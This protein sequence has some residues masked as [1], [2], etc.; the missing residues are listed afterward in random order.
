MESF[1]VDRPEEVS[2]KKRRLERMTALSSADQEAAAGNGGLLP[3]RVE[4]I[5]AHP[6]PGC[7][8]PTGL[9]FSPDD[10]RIAFL[11]SADGTLHHQVFVLDTVERRQELLFT[12][13]DGGGLEEGNLSADERLRRERSRERGL[14][15]TYYEW[16]FDPASGRDGIVVPLPS[17]VYFQDLCGS[18]PELKL[19]S[20]PSSPI[21]D[22]H[23][24]PN[25]S[26]IAFVRD[27]DLYSSDFSDGVIRQ[28]TFGARDSKKTRGLA[29]YIAQEEMERKT[30]IW[31]S[32]DSKKLAFT[33]V[34]SSEVPLYR[35][36]HQGK[37]YT[38]P[39]AQEDHAYP[40]A[41][42]ANAKVRLGVVP[43]HGG[44]ITWMD[45]L[46]GDQNKSNGGKE[47]Y[48]GR[49]IWMHN[50]ALAVQ[51]LNRTHTQL[52][53][54]K[55][56]I[57]TGKRKV[58]LEEKHDI[59]V[60][61]NDYFTPLDKGENDR[62]ENCFIWASEKTGFRHLYLHG[63]G[64]TCVAP[65]TQG[66][67]MVDQVVAVN[68]CTGLIYFT[69][70]MDGPL[71]S[72]LY[73]TNL[74]PDRGLP[75]QTP[76]RLTSG[77]GWHSV[78]LD[79]QLLRFIDVYESVKSP[80]VISLCSLI[81]GSVIFSIYQPVTVPRLINLQQF[82]PEIVRISAKDGN[83]LYANIYLPD[84]KQF[85]PP[86][87]RTVISVY[88]GPSAQFV[89]DS[90]N[91]TVDMRAQYLRSKGILVWKLDN[92]GT[93]RRGL[94][95]EGHLKYNIGCVDA[96]DQL[97]G[98]EWLIKQ[99]L[100][101]PGHI[102]MFGWSYGGFLS[103]MCLARFPEIFCCAVAGAPVT[104]WD[105]YD[106][107]YTEKYMGLPSENKDAYEFGSIMHHVNNLKGKLLL[108]HGMMD[109]NVHF[110]HTAR[111]INSLIAARKHYELLIFPDERHMPRGLPSRLYMEERI[112]EFLDR[113]L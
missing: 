33:E 62:Y 10:Q 53:L 32:P 50:G 48:L 72:H 44:E 6:L 98:A 47:G 3:M 86:P 82:P 108:V 79:H 97:T 23:L 15:V 42:E 63:N 94:Q 112:L 59:W 80:P 68:E 73:Q 57:A 40:F 29:E 35:I 38:G 14:G 70:S 31:W 110:R 17:G 64:G 74:F 21:I 25:G 30:G 96:E 107:F 18:E 60:T 20:T 85:G 24:S 52:K 113:N 12:A 65:L 49:V 81:D 69:G 4:E 39:N 78:I 84:E 76:K 45:I 11:F 34:D 102:G 13:P 27:D 91:S 111:L 26:M 16:R 7:E 71:E 22:P 93:S 56:D 61:I 37:N 55:F 90:W 28:L 95:F 104:A 101:V 41:G 89:Y 54:L 36:M 46:C 67:W 105:G 99:G 19:P 75:I 100:A 51:V 87:Y 2:G 58:L 1:G 9:S 5:V 83:S 103:A 92:R 77:T 106:T 66:D 109:E 43:S 88:G 8:A